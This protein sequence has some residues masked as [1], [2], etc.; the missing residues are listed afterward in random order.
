[1][2]TKNNIRRNYL[3]IKRILRG[4]LPS[5]EAIMKFLAFYDSS[6]T[7]RTFQ[8]DLAN[9]RSNFDIEIVYDA[10]NNG[11]YIDKEASSD[12]SKLLYFIELAECSDITI[13]SI[14]DKKDTL[15]YLSISPAVK[16]KG[17]ELIAPLL[18]AIKKKAVVLFNHH[19]YSTG[20]TRQY[21]VEPYLLKEFNS[22]WYLFAYVREK[23]AFRTFGLDRI[24]DLTISD[25]RFNRETELE[26]TANKFDTVY[27]LVYEPEQN[28]NAKIE[29]VRLR[30]S[31]IMINHLEASPL[32]QSQKADKEKGL[33]TWQVIINPELE[34]KIL[35][36]G[37]HAE[38]LS[39]NW[40]REKIKQR[41]MQVLQKY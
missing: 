7:L 41:L 15:R 1:M 28:K 24:D 32:H 2:A 31:P 16:T 27:G 26:E 17:I 14:V 6:V 37:E 20:E 10:Q 23:N 35:S 29:E 33:I 40:L 21:I 18:Q 39:P 19:N 25:D 34:N 5:A 4:D 3:I 11:Y 9:I 36:F 12:I 8:R 22:R 30:M 13:Q 38:V